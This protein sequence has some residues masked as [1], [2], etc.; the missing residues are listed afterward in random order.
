[1]RRRANTASTACVSKTAATP[2]RASQGTNDDD[3]RLSAR[4]FVPSSLG[5]LNFN[6]GELQETARLKQRHLKPRNFLS[7][8]ASAASAPM[9]VVRG[10]SGGLMGTKRRRSSSKVQVGQ[11]SPGRDLTLA[12]RRSPGHDS[13][14]S[15]RNGSLPRQARPLSYEPRLTEDILR[16]SYPGSRPRR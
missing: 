4:A 9:S 8:A 16:S 7:L 13:P 2:P 10:V 5:A 1:M 6:A 14:V 15:A 12:G 11:A 3:R